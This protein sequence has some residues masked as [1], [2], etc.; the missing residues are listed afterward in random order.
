MMDLTFNIAAPVLFHP[1]K[2]HLRYIQH[3]IQTTPDPLFYEDLLR[4]GAAQMDVY[5][6]ALSPAELG[7]EIVTNLQECLVF[8]EPAFLAH[9]ATKQ[10]YQSITV[11]DGS[12]WTLRQ[13]NEPK[14][15]VHIH[16]ARY[17]LHTV[18]VKAGAL[19]TAMLMVRAGLE[20][21][22]DTA[23]INKLRMGIGLSPIKNVGESE[24]I[25]RA[26]KMIA[27]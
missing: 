18:R 19:K 23:L 11:S 7:V 1:L 16:P 22:E 5:L 12:A 27:Q 24:G 9:L 6:G 2:H 25:R 17:A 8:E 3:F 21:A 20:S 4:I 15:Y 14:K 13:G 10:G 26:W